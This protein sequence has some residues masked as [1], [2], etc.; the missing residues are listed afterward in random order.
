M[1]G[2]NKVKVQA[3]VSACPVKS[4]LKLLILSQTSMAALLGLGMDK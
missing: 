3:N 4:G 2:D 1:H